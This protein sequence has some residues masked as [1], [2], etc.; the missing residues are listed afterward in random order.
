MILN[1]TLFLA[2]I[3]AF[4]LPVLIYLGTQEQAVQQQQEEL[5]GIQ[6]YRVAVGDV[7]TSVEASGEVESE[8]E[9][10]LSFEAGGRIN[11]L[12]IQE[13][14]YVL[15][16]SILAVLENDMQQL[17]YQQASLSVNRAELS[18]YDTLVTDDKELELASESLRAAWT[19]LGNAD[20]AVT[21]AD[22]DAMQVQYNELIES[23]TFIQMRADQAPGG[24][25]S[26]SYN[27]L[28][29]QAGEAWFNAELARLQ[30]ESAVENEQ[31]GLNA[32]YG[33]VLKAQTD[34][35]VLLA[36]PNDYTLDRVNL[37]VDQALFDLSHSRQD[38]ADTF[39]IAP[40]DGVISN[41]TVQDGSLVNVG[42]QIMQLTDVNHLKVT[43]YV[44][45]IDIGQVEN[46]KTVILTVDAIPGMEFD[47]VVSKIAPRSSIRD[48]VVV[49]DVELSV[50]DP[51][52][53][54]R[55]GMTVDAEIAL[56]QVEDT[57]LVPSSFVRRNPNGQSTIIILHP[58]GTREE[59]L[60]GTGLRGQRNTEILSG[61][62]PGELILQES[63]NLSGSGS[64]FGG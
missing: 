31:P 14:D 61:V 9:V 35:E 52:V 16:G 51:D 48:G 34:L 1:R 60:V 5:S 45:E 24:F 28:Q 26:D 41:L 54:L 33:S 44:D 32:A 40:N 17:G 30:M 63:L 10:S 18:R 12:F 3:I 36:G 49:Y 19:G 50:D 53:L 43:I 23:A 11:E 15:E 13:G 38:Y 56:E 27:T 4:V 7:R 25:N 39:L 20:N 6:V 2:A 46:D 64:P 62:I 21:N 47:G 37:Q 42:G 59:R 55:V 57:I 8:N 58:D 29:S 22:I